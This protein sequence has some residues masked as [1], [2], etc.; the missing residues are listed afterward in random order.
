MTADRGGARGGRRQS[1]PRPE[2]RLARGIVA[3][4]LATPAIFA[5]ESCKPLSFLGSQL[6]VFVQPFYSAPDWIDVLEDRERVERLICAIEEEVSG[7][8]DRNTGGDGSDSRASE[9]AGPG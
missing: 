9:S 5:L 4:G 3:R 2:E 6:L 8:S 1:P 7:K